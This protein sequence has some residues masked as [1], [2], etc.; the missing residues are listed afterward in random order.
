[1]KD[2]RYPKDSPCHFCENR[3]EKCHSKCEQYK[4]FR[5]HVDEHHETRRAKYLGPI[6][7]A[8]LDKKRKNGRGLGKYG[9]PKTSHNHWLEDD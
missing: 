2:S 4:E 9:K 1:M 6:Y 5:Q 3:T 7:N 8:D